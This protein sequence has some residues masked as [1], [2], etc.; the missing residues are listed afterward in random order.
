MTSN[1]A[2]VFQLYTGRQALPVAHAKVTVATNGNTVEHVLYTNSSGRSPA[3]PLCAPPVELSLCPNPGVLPFSLCNARIEAAGFLPVD[4][5]GIQ[6]FAGQEALESMELNPTPRNADPREGDSIIIP[7]PALVTQQPRNPESIPDGQIAPLVL[8]S[9]Y[10]PRYLTVHLGSPNN[11]SAPNVTVSFQDYIKNVASSEIYPTWP[12]NALRANLYAQISFAL[13]RIYTEWYPS[14]GYS[15]NITNNTAYDQAYVHGRN[16]F[17]NISS[18]V[19]EIFNEYVRKKGTV[20]PY[21]T[22]YCNGTTVTC[23][24]MSQW[25]TVPLAQNGYSPLNILRQSY[26]YEIEL[27]AT[28]DIRSIE[29]SYPGTPLQLGSSGPSVRTIENQL[30]RIRRNYPAIP[31]IPL[32]GNSF[33][34]QT[35]EAVQA[36]QRIFTLPVDGIVGRATWNKISYIYVAVKRLSELNSE[37]EENQLPSQPPTNLLRLGDSGAYVKLAQY[38]LRVISNYYEAVRPVAID[39]SFGPMTQAAVRDFQN[40][41][42]LEIDGIVGPLTWQKLYD[43]F[44]GIANTS[45]LAVAYPGYLLQLGSRGENVWLMQDYL[46]TIAQR[47]PLPAPVPDGIFGAQT[48]AAVTAFQR[49]FGLTPDGIIGQKTWNRI[50]TVRLLL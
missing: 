21:F 16:I 1:T 39:G 29:S 4:I 46:S 35:Q 37:G 17:S 2:L 24:G 36:F 40:R 9:V 45:G 42:G 20:N 18:L 38:F 32:V 6:L 22:E 41:F 8:S 33:T 30:N 3:L 27:V 23:A 28:E 49:S 10:I 50:V 13:N 12:E 26:G 43:V 25:G 5:R 14:R 47:Y 15:F 48:K 7:P 34:R 11:S 19:D 44:L 31:L